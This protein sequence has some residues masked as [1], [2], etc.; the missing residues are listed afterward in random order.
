LFLNE[1][2]PETREVLAAGDT[3]A[4]WAAFE[5]V[6]TACMACHEAE[7]MAYM[8]NM[9]MFDELRAPGG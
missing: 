8:N 6:R 5:R 2:W 9:A 7:N 4:S 1:V 3:A